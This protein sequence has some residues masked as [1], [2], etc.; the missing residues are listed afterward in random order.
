MDTGSLPLNGFVIYYHCG[1]PIHV[2]RFQKRIRVGD[3]EPLGRPVTP[4]P[5]FIVVVL[6]L[7]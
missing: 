1:F 3:R 7:K 5:I 6:V 2:H 4:L